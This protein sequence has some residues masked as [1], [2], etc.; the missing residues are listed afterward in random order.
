MPSARTLAGL[1]DSDSEDDLGRSL[2]AIQSSR[3]VAEMP[4]SRKQRARTG[5]TASKVTK[6]AQK[7]TRR[8]SGRAKATIERQ[9]LAK[10]NENPQAGSAHT[11]DSGSTSGEVLKAKGVRGRPRTKTRLGDGAEVHNQVANG[12]PDAGASRRGL[13]TGRKGREVMEVAEDLEVLHP[14]SMDLDI[15]GNAQCEPPPQKQPAVLLE[16]SVTSSQDDAVDRWPYDGS[17]MDRADSA[18]RKQLREMTKKYEALESKYREL[19]DVGINEAEGNFDRFKKHADEQAKSKAA[20]TVKGSFANQY[21]SR[22][23]TD[24]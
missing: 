21:D 1:V 7:T 14:D 11:E 20:T 18:D 12:M 13:R 4:A 9:A 5:V 6:Q 23:P 15:N 8:T 24:F 2:K 3:A 22:E 16:Q 17:D 10:K 19:R